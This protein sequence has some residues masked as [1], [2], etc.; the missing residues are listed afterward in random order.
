MPEKC[1]ASGPPLL[2]LAHSIPGAPRFSLLVA[3]LQSNSAVGTGGWR[4]GV[5]VCVGVRGYTGGV[6]QPA[7]STPLPFPE[8]HSWVRWVQGEWPLGPG[9]DLGL[10]P[11]CIFPNLEPPPSWPSGGLGPPGCGFSLLAGTALF[12]STDLPGAGSTPGRLI[13]PISHIV[14]P[15]SLPL[16]PDTPCHHLL[17]PELPSQSPGVPLALL[18]WSY[19]FLQL[20]TGLPP[21]YS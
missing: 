4:C 13:L 18:L 11:I 12:G 3:Q 1:A 20:Q 14:D 9:A 5:Y 8:Y 2:P 10:R 15:L 17:P 21:V 16:G 19:H 7:L 6:R